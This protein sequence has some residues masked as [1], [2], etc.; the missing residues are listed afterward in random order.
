MKNILKAISALTLLCFPVTSF[1]LSPKISAD[2]VEAKAEAQNAN[3]AKLAN[4]HIRKSG[5]QYYLL[6][7]VGINEYEGSLHFTE[8]DVLLQNANCLNNKIHLYKKDKETE[9]ENA[10]IS[11]SHYGVWGEKQS[12]SF[13]LKPG[14]TGRNISKLTVDK[15]T[16]LPSPSK[17]LYEFKSP[18]MANNNYVGLGDDSTSFNCFISEHK[19]KFYG[20]EIVLDLNYGEKIGNRIP[21]V[22]N[23]SSAKPI[24]WLLD[25][26]YLDES[27][28]WKQL[29]DRTAMP[30]YSYD[31]FTI[32]YY[33]EDGSTIIEEQKCRYKSKIHLLEVPDSLG[34]KGKWEAVGDAYKTMPNHD[35]FYRLVYYQDSFVVTFDELGEEQLVKGGDYALRPNDPIMEGYLFHHWVNDD[36]DVYDFSAPVNANIKLY[37]VFLRKNNNDAIYASIKTGIYLGSASIGAGAMFLVKVIMK[38]RK[39]T[40]QK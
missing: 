26:D 38:K 1:G 5:S 27:Y 31:F 22:P 23:V 16:T 13:V 9:I 30:Q 40:R 6:L 36:G 37:P 18:Y 28:V 19:L 21:E 8:E 34:L 10:I 24:G 35:I 25:G 12:I 2:F 33:G 29:L 20:T 17:K 39:K 32:Y 4:V 14:I 15:G 11:P 7:F 3:E